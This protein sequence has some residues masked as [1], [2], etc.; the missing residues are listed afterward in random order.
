MHG[1]VKTEIREFLLSR[2]VRP[3]LVL[4]TY[5]DFLYFNEVQ[6]HHLLIDFHRV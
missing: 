3:I 2:W 4:Q 1:A 5:R 6:L